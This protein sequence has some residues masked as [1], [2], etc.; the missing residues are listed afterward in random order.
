MLLNYH[1]SEVMLCEKSSLLKAYNTLLNVTL[2]EDLS[3]LLELGLSKGLKNIQ[4]ECHPVKGF[5]Q[6]LL[7][8]PKSIGFRLLS[9]LL[10]SNNE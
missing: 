9:Q 2:L 7:N 3:N 1:S 6:W 5:Q 4:V 10:E 8:Q